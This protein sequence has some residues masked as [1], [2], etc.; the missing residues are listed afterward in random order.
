MRPIGPVPELRGSPTVTRRCTRPTASMSCSRAG[1][2]K[3]GTHDSLMI[4]SGLYS[5]VFSLQPAL[6]AKVTT[7]GI[8]HDE[9]RLAR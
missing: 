4:N 3:A 1:S 7:G 5:E 6:I 9:P 2:S 8:I